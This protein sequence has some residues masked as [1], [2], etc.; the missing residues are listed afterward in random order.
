MA[1]RKLFFFFVLL[2]VIA[3][4]TKKGIHELA[5]LYWI[6]IVIQFQSA[7]PLPVFVFPCSVLPAEIVVVFGYRGDLFLRGR[8][9]I[10]RD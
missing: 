2:V 5:V 7:L 3:E 6:R 9:T 8:F 10:V 4:H 1:W